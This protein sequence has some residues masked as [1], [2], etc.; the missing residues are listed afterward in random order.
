MLSSRW[1]K[2]DRYGQVIHP[3]DICVYNNKFVIY[4]KDSWGGQKS[5]GE[6][7]RFE[8]EAGTRTIKYTNVVFAF[9][10]MGERRN[11]STT[12]KGLCRKFYEGK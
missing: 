4:I 12:I 8:T 6:Y 10:P 11:Q 3:G 7:G 2:Q 5:K 1:K 9:D